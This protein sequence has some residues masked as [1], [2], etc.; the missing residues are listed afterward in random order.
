M[1][2]NILNIGFS[3]DVASTFA[4]RSTYVDENDNGDIFYYIGTNF[5]TSAWSNPTSTPFLSITNTGLQPASINNL[6][7]DN[8]TTRLAGNSNSGLSM[9][10]NLNFTDVIVQPTLIQLAYVNTASGSPG[11]SNVFFD[12]SNDGSTWT[13]LID[14]ADFSAD[15]NSA[16][17]IW[18]PPETITDLRFW[19]NLRLRW[20]TTN[21][22]SS[23]NFSS[24]LIYGNIKR[25]DGGTASRVSL[26]Q[27]INELP[28]VVINSAQ[29]GD[30]LE[31]AG[32]VVRSKREKLY[33]TVRTTNS[34][35]TEEAQYLPNFYII[36]PSTAENFDLPPNPI[37]GQFFRVRNL[38]NLFQ[39]DIREP[40]PTVVASIGG[41]GG[42]GLTQADC[43]YDGTEWTIITY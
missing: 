13:E 6:T 35:T 20:T 17:G 18:L 5:G 37:A 19:T 30:Y 15:A 8:Q 27:T 34:V 41:A 42:P 21:S 38:D 11:Y 39:I 2:F 9:V 43:Y 29:D 22:A 10:F 4:D 25:T 33:E 1:A 32:G 12:G 36:T 24:L 40:G 16:S 3:G 26:P 7:D 28:D 14:I 31:W 23:N